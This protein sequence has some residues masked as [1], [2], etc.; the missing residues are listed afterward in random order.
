MGTVQR[1]GVPQR[2]LIKTPTANFVVAYKAKD[3]AKKLNGQVSC[4]LAANL[5]GAAN[6]WVV[7]ERVSGA[8]QAPTGS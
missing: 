8:D 7:I 6:W 2:D 1:C 3:T 5:Y 4:E